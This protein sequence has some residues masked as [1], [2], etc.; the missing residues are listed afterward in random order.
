MT[1]KHSPTRVLHRQLTSC[2]SVH[3]LG[4]V[5]LRSDLATLQSLWWRKLADLYLQWEK[6]SGYYPYSNLSRPILFSLPYL[7]FSVSSSL[8]SSLFSFLQLHSSPYQ[9]RLDP[10][11]NHVPS[12][13]SHLYPAPRWQTVCYKV[14]LIGPFP[15]PWVIHERLDT[16][17]E[18]EINLLLLERHILLHRCKKM[19]TNLRSGLRPAPWRHG[20]RDSVYW[21]SVSV[22]DYG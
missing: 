22:P 6:G 15:A 8:S 18:P 2:T 10:S 11:S 14:L 12:V 1:P 3:R 20:T 19:S 4:W 17:E 9:L 21:E 16:E 13:A 5:C 7:S